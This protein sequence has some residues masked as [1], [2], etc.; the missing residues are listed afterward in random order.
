MENYL[1][2]TSKTISLL[3]IDYSKQASAQFSIVIPVYQRANA[4]EGLLES[5]RLQDIPSN[6]NSR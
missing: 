6:S 3:K 2:D 4:L 5:I 1:I